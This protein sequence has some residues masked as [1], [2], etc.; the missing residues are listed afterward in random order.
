MSSIG[1]YQ[2]SIRPVF[3]A[4]L[5]AVLV[6]ALIHG[7]V[8]LSGY[9]RKEQAIRESCIRA[10]YIDALRAGERHYCIKLDHGST[11]VV[12]APGEPD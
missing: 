7:L 8:D 5:V 9:F 10:G 4:V 11:L 3:L 12:R 2:P 1:D 6:L